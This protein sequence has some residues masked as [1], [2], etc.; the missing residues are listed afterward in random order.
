MIRKIIGGIVVGVLAAAV[1]RKVADGENGEFT[2]RIKGWFKKTDEFDETEE[3]F[4]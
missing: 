1:I 2:N 4:E 3:V